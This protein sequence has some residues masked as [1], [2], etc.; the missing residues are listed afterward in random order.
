MVDLTDIDSVSGAI[1]D[2]LID[3][4][5]R[6]PGGWTLVGAQ[7]VALHGRQ[8]DRTPPRATSDA[9][10]LVDVRIVPEG[11]ARFSKLL[12]ENGYELEGIDSF[13]VGHR[14]TKGRV[15]I[16]LLAP[17]GL[18]RGKKHLVTLSP[19]RTVAIPGGTQALRRTWLVDIK[20]K[21]RTGRIPCPDLLGAILLKARA[22][23]VDDVPASQLSDLAF[24][25]S[26]VEDPRKLVGQFQ[27][28]ER[29][30]LRRRKELSDRNHRVWREQPEEEAD[31]G[32]IAFRILI[33]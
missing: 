15:K 30:W 1:W 9:D 24:L 18:G 2:A 28:K 13:G 14:F 26:L 29:S 10:V 20:R 5:S 17:D 4:A 16:D 7:M 12:V 22:V 21:A 6:Q 31:N 3:L 27:G 8:R 33:G 11:T 23:E 25:L 32:H 19:A